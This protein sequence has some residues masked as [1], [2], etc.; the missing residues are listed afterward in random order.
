MY[1]LTDYGCASGNDIHS[2]SLFLFDCLIQG[3]CKNLKADW[4]KAAGALKGVVNVA[5]VDATENQSLAQKYG[6]QVCNHTLSMC[7]PHILQLFAADLSANFAP[8]HI[9][10]AL[11]WIKSSLGRNFVC[12]ILRCIC[13]IPVLRLEVQQESSLLA[14]PLAVHG[15]NFVYSGRAIGSVCVRLGGRKVKMGYFVRA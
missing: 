6:V 7:C 5:A 10:C 8:V 14:E 9:F 4:E 12:G 1:L 2:Y 13:L 15:Y 3:H 11:S